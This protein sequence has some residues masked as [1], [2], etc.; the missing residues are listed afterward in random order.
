MV[1]SRCGKPL[2]QGATT[3]AACGAPGIAPMLGHGGAAAARP[4]A[5]AAPGGATGYAGFWLRLVAYVIDAF[6]VGLVAGFA[7]SF[8][9]GI[10]GGVVGA[11][12]AAPESVGAI[13]GLV[14]ALVAFVLGWLY[15]AI[16]ESSGKQATLGKMALGIAVTDGEGRPIGFG[17][18][19]GR[20]F[21]KLLSAFPLL[22]GFL[23]AAF[24][25]R[26]QA[27]HDLV[28]GTL[29]VKRREGGAGVVIAVVAA[30]GLGG[31]VVVGILAAIA[32]P[33]FIRYQLRAKASE[34]SMQLMGI[35]AAEASQ[36]ARTRKYFSLQVPSGGRPGPLR[37]PWSPDDLAAASEVGWPVAESSYFSYRV[38][39]VASAEGHQAFSACAEADLDGD[40]KYAAWVL[41]HPALDAARNVLAAPP[42]PPCA[43]EPV[44]SRSP[45]FQP[46][47]PA[48]Q[49]VKISPD[50]A[51]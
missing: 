30:V 38:A 1:C 19:T 31:I 9:G 23:V 4:A 49:P 26:K 43:H 5:A 20:Y 6:V 14:G 3:C 44:L 36:L 11:S 39:A 42:P 29:V 32:I 22:I 24:T 10:A 34:A 37:M 16:L 2:P 46:G 15:F 40:G 48:G 41:W 18:A 17:R 7:G 47:D 50:S 27:L 12:G 45:L 21:A 28:A 13:V 35:E 51:F 8:I 25:G 33:N